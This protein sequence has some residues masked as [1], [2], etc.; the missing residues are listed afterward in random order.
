MEE[1]HEQIKQKK[2]EFV[3]I[4]GTEIKEMWT[5][6]LKLVEKALK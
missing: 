3:K 1:L 2:D 4:K 6:D 5:D